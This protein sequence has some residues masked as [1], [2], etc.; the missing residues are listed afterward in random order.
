M[1]DQVSTEAAAP[2]AEDDFESAFKEAAAQRE[3]R[4]PQDDEPAAKEATEQKADGEAPATK[5]GTK[6]DSPAGDIQAELEAE[7]KRAAEFEHK[8]RSEVGRQAALQRQIQELQGRINQAPQPAASAAPRSK[9]MQKLVEDFPEIAEAL[10]AELETRLGSVKNEVDQ[11]LQ[12]IAAKEQERQAAAEEAAVKDAYPNM[13][14]IVNSTEFANWLPKQPQAVQALAASPRAMD[15]IAL[16]DYFTGGQ[17]PQ[18]G[19]ST[20]QSIQ[21]KRAQQLSRHVSVKNTAPPPVADAPDDFAS[22]FKFF[23]HKRERQAAR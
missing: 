19:A 14:E 15:A 21:E 2:A 23:A 11:R 3:G 13:V 10:E 1:T 16:I 5:D 4:A 9:Q 17:R 18:Q 7:R 20:V 6:Q 22:A 12:P 8:F